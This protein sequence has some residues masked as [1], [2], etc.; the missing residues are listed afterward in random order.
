[1]RPGLTGVMLVPAILV[2]SS[3]WAKPVNPFAR[4]QENT[5]K[6]AHSHEVVV[7]QRPVLKGLIIAGPGSI[8][9]LN[10]TLLAIGESFAGYQLKSVDQ[11]SATFLYG[12]KSVTLFVEEPV[13][14]DHE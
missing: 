2:A 3:L 10:G 6:P 9:N 5:T 1:M 8:A 4:P 13:D 12:N 11:G 14:E 7:S